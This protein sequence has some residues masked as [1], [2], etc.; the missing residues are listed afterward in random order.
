MALS[1]RI[2]FNLRAVLSVLAARADRRLSSDS[3]SAKK[4]HKVH[5]AR[6][7]WK[8]NV[9]KLVSRSRLSSGGIALPDG[10]SVPAN[11]AT[12]KPVHFQMYS[13]VYPVRVPPVRQARSLS[14]IRVCFFLGEKE[15]QEAPEA[16]EDE[17]ASFRLFIWRACQAAHQLALLCLALF[18]HPRTAA[19]AATAPHTHCPLHAPAKRPYH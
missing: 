15:E 17:S 10:V 9:K 16:R 12:N 6:R 14:L 19:A 11:G 13:Q 8:R 18:F 1:K 3:H 2:I 7:L 4:V 5:R